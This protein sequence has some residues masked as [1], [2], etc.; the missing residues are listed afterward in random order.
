MNSIY[1]IYI[2]EQQVKKMNNQ[3]CPS[4]TSSVIRYLIIVS[5][6][7]FFLIDEHF[8]L[9]WIALMCHG[10]SIPYPSGSLTGSETRPPKK[11]LKFPNI[12]FSGVNL[13]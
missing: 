10:R 9:G 6:R 13:L 12:C 8:H 7:E 3:Y 4:V 5:C 2:Y 1:I 11:K